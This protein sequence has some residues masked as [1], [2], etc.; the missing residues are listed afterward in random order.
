MQP[1]MLQGLR[2][3]GRGQLDVWR[4]TV[5]ASHGM[6]WHGMAQCGI[7]WCGMAIAVWYGP[8]THTH[9]VMY[10][11]RNTHPAPMV[12]SSSGPWRQVVFHW[13]SLSPGVWHG[14]PLQRQSPGTGQIRGGTAILQALY[15]HRIMPKLP[16]DTTILTL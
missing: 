16:M 11:H 1:R 10:L 6:A 5:W 14:G 2:K 4:G 8:H 12:R 15:V 3:D 13:W 7:V 9:T